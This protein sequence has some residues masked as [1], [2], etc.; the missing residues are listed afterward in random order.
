MLR[1]DLLEIKCHDQAEGSDLDAQHSTYKTRFR[2]QSLAVLLQ[3]VNQKAAEDAVG[4]GPP[5]PPPPP[6]GAAPP[7]QP[8][9]H[10]NNTQDPLSWNSAKI[11][12]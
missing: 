10:K 3:L 2:I 1:P 9:R 6:G 4:G 8:K 12:A 5:R 11:G 7:P